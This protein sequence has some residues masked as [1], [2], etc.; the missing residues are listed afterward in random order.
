MGA[1]GSFEFP[2]SGYLQGK[3][4]W[5]EGD[6]D[7]TKNTSPVTA[8]L[9]AR[10]TNNYTTKGS[11]WKGW[12]HVDGTGADISFSSSVSVSNSWVEMARTTQNVVH[13]DDGS[14]V[15]GIDGSVTGPTGTALS[16]NTSSGTNYVT[17]VTIPRA[18][19]VSCTSGNIGE[20]V[21]I[22]ISRASSNFKHDLIYKFGNIS[23]TIV[24]KTSETNIGWTI[25]TGFYTQVPSAT[26][27]MGTI[28]CAT[29]NGDTQI[30]TSTCNFTAYV[31]NSNPTIKGTVVDSNEN[32]IALTGSNTKLIKYMSNAYIAA[33]ATAKNSATISLVK[34]TCADGKRATAFPTTLNNIES[35][36]FTFETKDTRGLVGTDTVILD[37]VD[38][39]KAAITSLSAERLE[40]TSNTITVK[41]KGQY[42]N[43]NFGKEDNS[44]TLKYRYRASENDE[45]SDFVEITPTVTDN[46]F[47]YSGNLA[48]EYDFQSSWYFEFVAKDKLIEYPVFKMVTAGIPLIDLWKGNFNVNGFIRENGTKLDDMLSDLK[49]AVKKSDTIVLAS[50][51]L[52]NSNLN[53]EISLGTFDLFPY[54]KIVIEIGQWK[55]SDYRI[56]ELDNNGY[57]VGDWGA[58]LWSY[59][60]SDWQSRAYAWI[61]NSQIKIKLKELVGWTSTNYRITG[62]LR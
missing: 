29:Y 55:E 28:T 52:T 46:T 45:W 23:G 51:S 54:K 24:T 41:L 15:V 26:A 4:E 18:S 59:A 2:A 47:S 43:G 39:I 38:Y 14:R 27:K 34:V 12:V 57:P 11:T 36:T 31:S 20:T 19:S 22:Y 16:G 58:C 6:Y 62:M 21:G 30:G 42:F 7:I 37:M 1:S 25:P 8:I 61:E 49:T 44:L 53:T 9:Y 33:T 5:F 48:E 17:L 40:S 10:R 60:G 50:G 32:T 13:N 56:I 3:I 35:G